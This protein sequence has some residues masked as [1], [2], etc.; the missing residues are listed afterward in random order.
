MPPSVL[1]TSPSTAH[2]VLLV[3][4]ITGNDKLLADWPADGFSREVYLI[5][6]QQ[7]GPLIEIDEGDVLEVFVRNELAVETTSH[8]HG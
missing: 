2:P 7:P 4:L 3:S 1:T 5:N 8:W 6:D